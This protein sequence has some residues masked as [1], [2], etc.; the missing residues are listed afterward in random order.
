[1]KSTKLRGQNTNLVL[2]G[3]NISLSR[4]SMVKKMMQTR[5]T[6]FTMFSLRKA[7]WDNSSSS[8]TSK[9]DSIK[10]VPVERKMRIIEVV[11]SI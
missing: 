5:S 6:Y 3:Q 9:D 2:F 8:S 11:V 10:K 4:N 1:M 7:D